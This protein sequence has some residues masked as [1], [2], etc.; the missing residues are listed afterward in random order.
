MSFPPLG[1]GNAVGEAA[2]SFWKSTLTRAGTQQ[3]G[4][5]DLNSPFLL[6]WEQQ[7]G[8]EGFMR[9]DVAQWLRAQGFGEDRAGFESSLWGASG[10]HLEWSTAHRSRCR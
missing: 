6:S 10:S 5:K 4:K 9:G 3:P 2:V 7:L 1:V 8:C